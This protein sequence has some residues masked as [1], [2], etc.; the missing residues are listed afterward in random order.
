MNYVT[1]I[2]DARRPAA[3]ECRRNSS[4]SSIPIENAELPCVAFNVKGFELGAL[5]CGKQPLADYLDIYIVDN[6]TLIRVTET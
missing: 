6:H 1:Y 3:E 4:T 2:V 5:P